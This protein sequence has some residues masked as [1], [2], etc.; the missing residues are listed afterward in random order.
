MG[1][2]I[3]I[4]ENIKKSE[5]K[6]L[7]FL[8]KCHIQTPKTIL[9]TFTYSFIGIGIYLLVS[10]IPTPFIVVPTSI[11]LGG[12]TVSLKLGFIYSIALIAGIGAIRGPVAGFIIGYLGSLFENLIF[13]TTAIQGTLPNLAYGL[14]GLI[15]G[16]G[17]YD[18][19]NGRSLIKVS[20][21]SFVGFLL[22]VILQT[23]SD[24]F[25]GNIPLMVAV[26][27]VIL[28]YATQG[29]PS[30]FLLTPLYL[31]VFEFLQ[32]GTGKFIQRKRQKGTID[33]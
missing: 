15:V 28:P 9:I 20:L 32:I 18:L 12:A 8:E 4:S 26:G 30:V 29:I 24:I 17:T 7:S 19:S 25:I 11:N 2:N 5:K 13:T 6:Q 23:V 14:L 22:T 27:L 33:K 31:R 21:L 10:L 16:L 1:E 3:V